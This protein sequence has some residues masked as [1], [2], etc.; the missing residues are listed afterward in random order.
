MKAATDDPHA[1]IKSNWLLNGGPVRQVLSD[2]AAYE[3]RIK[4][5]ERE[6]ATKADITMVWME[7]VTKKTIFKQLTSIL[8]DAIFDVRRIERDVLKR[9]FID[10]GG[11]AWKNVQ[12]WVGQGQTLTR[13]GINV[14]ENPVCLYSGI[15]VERVRP[16]DA[17]ILAI[18]MAG[19]GCEGD[20]PHNLFL[21]DCANFNMSQNLLESTLPS[22][23]TMPH[24][25]SLN[26]SGNGL[27]GTL[28]TA[29]L[30]LN[31][32]I[33]KLDMSFNELSGTIPDVFDQIPNLR[34]LNLSGNSFE[35]DLPIS[36][37]S[38]VSLEELRLQNNRLTGEISSDLTKLVSLR[39]A[40]LSQ[41]M[42]T[43]GHNNFFFLE[44]LEML[45]LNN[46]RLRGH[47]TSEIYRARK[48]FVLQLQYNDL[49]GRLPDEICALQ[50]LRILNLTKN[51][52][53]GLLPELIGSMVSLEVLLLGEN[54]FLGP[55]PLSLAQLPK[56]KDFSLF[57]MYPADWSGPK[58]VFDRSSFQRIYEAG[59]NFG[60]D[61]INWQYKHVYGRDR[62]VHDD[63]TVT[64][65]SGVL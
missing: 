48:L 25:Q 16:E 54:N 42:F 1:N 61:S 8:Y 6:N 14:L 22:F 44:N 65:F 62:S 28:H 26:L 56:L 40:N 57:K 18:E 21:Q 50:R 13:E 41:N 29:S 24:L 17:A 12:G 59:P 36:L 7:I 33:T 63:E 49:S 23:S 11:F 55:V 27:T 20:I 34:I 32:S 45:Q 53:R 3:R 35:G 64:L 60:I 31:P 10:L 37:Y 9:F 39:H 46:N 19:Q 30:H 38:L 2:I 4:R 52:L 51:H 47:I 58:R 43:G 15:H 5:M